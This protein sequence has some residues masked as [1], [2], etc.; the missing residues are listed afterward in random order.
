MDPLPSN[1]V[2][3]QLLALLRSSHALLGVITLADIVALWFSLK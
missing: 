3:V 2:R 1:S